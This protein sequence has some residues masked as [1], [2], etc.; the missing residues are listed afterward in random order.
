MSDVTR[1][2]NPSMESMDSTDP[3]NS[4]FGESIEEDEIELSAAEVIFSICQLSVC[5]VRYCESDFAGDLTT[6][7][8][9]G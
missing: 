1:F 6:W 5:L 4:L 9:M 8:S 3:H 7:N 2:T